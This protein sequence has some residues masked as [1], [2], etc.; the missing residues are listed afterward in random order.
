MPVR[1]RYL[2]PKE[3][4]DP[5][6]VGGERYGSCPTSHSACFMYKIQEPF[7]QSTADSPPPSIQFSSVR[8]QHRDNRAN[9]RKARALGRPSVIFVDRSGVSERGFL[10]VGSGRREVAA[11]S[12]SV[13]TAVVPLCFQ[14]KLAAN[15]YLPPPLL[16]P[17][18]SQAVGPLGCL[19]QLAPEGG[20]S[21]SYKSHHMT[22]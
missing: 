11:G 20:P 21:A 19:A 12:Y 18:P 5:A 9:S 15:R 14:S 7:V 1:C 17:P 6:K 10:A 4:A 22:P 13:R 3:F 2:F 8:I 16:P